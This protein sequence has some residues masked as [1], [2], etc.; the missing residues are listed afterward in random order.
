[1]A[2]TYNLLSIRMSVTTLIYNQPR[3]NLLTKNLLQRYLIHEHELTSRDVWWGVPFRNCVCDVESV[4]RL[5]PS[6]HA[7]KPVPLPPPALCQRSPFFHKVTL[8]FSTMSKCIVVSICYVLVPKLILLC[9][10]CF[11]MQAFQPVKLNS[12]I[13][14]VSN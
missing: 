4:P 2:R 5:M 14:N 7:S 13:E 8:S 3:E 9:L 6:P 12:F 10:S 1:M 11:L